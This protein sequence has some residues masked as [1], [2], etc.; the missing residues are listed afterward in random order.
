MFDFIADFIPNR[1]VAMLTAPMVIFSY[2]HWNLVPLQFLTIATFFAMLLFAIGAKRA[3]QIGEHRLFSAIA[4]LIVI[5]QL[6]VLL[7]GPQM[8]DVPDATEFRELFISIGL[9]A[10]AA[11]YAFDVAAPDTAK[12]A[13]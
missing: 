4:A 9:F 12:P 8:L 2:G 11:Y 5:G 6:L 10:F 13:S 7:F 1:A 3:G